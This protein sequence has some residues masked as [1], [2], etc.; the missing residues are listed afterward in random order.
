MIFRPTILSTYK[1]K[2]Y[3]RKNKRTRW[4][5]AY[6]KVLADPFV[7]KYKNRNIIFFEDMLVL[8]GRISC[9]LLD[10]KD[11]NIVPILNDVRHFSYPCPI[12][13]NDNLYI[14]PETVCDR[15]I[16]LYKCMNFPYDWKFQ[17]KLLEG[18][19]FV[20]SN[21][22]YYQS[23]FW[24]F[25]FISEKPNGYLAIYYSDSLTGTYKE[26]PI[27]KEKIFSNN[28]NG[29]GRGAGSIHL[30]DDHIIRPIQYNP[31]YYGQQVM[32]LKIKFNTKDYQQWFYKKIFIPK[33]KKKMIGTHH[34]SENE[35]YIVSDYQFK[36]I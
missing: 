13:H 4:L 33:N 27:N 12:I 3:N 20:D 28:F 34:V 15:S 10:S 31:N 18:H 30:F 19:S 14:V 2:V 26:H 35:D 8:N 9:C 36:F 1:I 17:T 16:R 11:K 25:T 29:T 6:K 21:I 7:I 22:F 24:I 32:Y 5:S 23:L